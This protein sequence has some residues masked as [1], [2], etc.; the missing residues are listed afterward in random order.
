MSNSRG[1][2]PAESS[3]AEPSP[4]VVERGRVVTPSAQIAD[5]AVVIEGERIAWV[6]AVAEAPREWAAAVAATAAVPGHWVLPGLVDLHNHGGGGAGFPD[7][8]TVDEA[9][10]AAREHL[11]HGTTSVVASLVT[12]PR[13][14]LVARTGLLADLVEEGEIVGIHLEGPF[15]APEKKGAHAE[16][17]LLD[18]DPASVQRLIEAG[19]PA[20]RMITM[21]DAFQFCVGTVGLAI[22]EVAAMA[23]TTP[24]RFHGLEDV[25]ELAVGKRADVCLVDDDGILHQV[26]HRGERVL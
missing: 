3:P 10:R 2:E 20:L 6:G 12:A 13:D 4:V 15:L 5:G 17:L 25:G 24:A 7:V 9:R 26:W 21:A 8:A 18:P 23:A 1:P 14:V 16:H 22:P 11:R 19:G